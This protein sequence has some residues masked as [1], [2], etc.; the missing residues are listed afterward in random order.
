M[1]NASD[2][3]PSLRTYAKPTLVKAAVLTQV[4]AFGPAPVP[5]SPIAPA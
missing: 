4:T 3:R 5:V 2:S 1:S